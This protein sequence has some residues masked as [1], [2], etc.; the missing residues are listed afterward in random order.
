MLRGLMGLS[1]GWA[2]VAVCADTLRQPSVFLWEDETGEVRH[3]QQGEGGEQGDPLMLL[4]FCL[5]QKTRRWSFSHC[6]TT[7]TLRVRIQVAPAKAHRT[8]ERNSRDTP[9]FPSTTGKPR[10]GTEEVMT[11][12]LSSTPKNRTEADEEAV[13]W[14]GH[15]VLPPEQQGSGVLATPLGRNLMH[16][17]A[18]SSVFPQLVTCRPLGCSCFTMLPRSRISSCALCPQVH[19]SVCRPT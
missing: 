1:I 18:C 16:A 11:S 9:T 8:L 13:V 7:C 3:I 19:F 2:L 17:V 10:C 15:A 4:L 12:K 5:A 6:L 14:R